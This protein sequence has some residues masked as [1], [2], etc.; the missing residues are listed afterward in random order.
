MFTLIK[1]F[2]ELSLLLSTVTDK[3][4]GRLPHMLEFG[5]ELAS[6]VRPTAQVSAHCP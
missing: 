3:L 4:L 2:N 5:V 1:S 6:H